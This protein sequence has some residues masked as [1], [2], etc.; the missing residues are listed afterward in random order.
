V[1]GALPLAYVEGDA[2]GAIHQA[3]A[4]AVA[5]LEARGLRLRTPP[6]IIVHGDGAA[7]RLA[8]GQTDRSLRAWSTWNSVQ[9]MPLST[10]TRPD[11]PGIRERVTH[12][13]CHVALYHGFGDEARARAVRIP[14]FF[15]EGV[16]S[17]IAQQPR[18]DL[19][20]SG[21]MPLES[22]AFVTDPQAAYAAAHRVIEFLD[23]KLEPRWLNDV[24]ERAAADGT[25]AAVERALLEVT[26]YDSVS[27]WKAVVAVAP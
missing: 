20:V 5:A 14:R 11:A 15:E 8:T 24:L 27:L 25:P 22:S 23:R 2:S 10:W 9:L 4:P 7:F 21:S 1:S 26:G 19:M 17:V 12:E 3:V 6:R 18:P 16:C 13:L